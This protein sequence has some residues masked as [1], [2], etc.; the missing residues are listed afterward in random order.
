MHDL[1]ADAALLRE[2]HQPGKPVIFAN[3]WDAASAKVVAQAGAKAIATSSIAVANAAGLPDTDVMPPEVAFGAVA[4]VS[5]AVTLPVTADLEAGYRLDASEF[6]SRLLQAGAVGCNIEDTDH[7]GAHPEGGGLVPLAVQAEKLAALRAAATAAGVPIVLNAR[8]DMFLP[9]RSQTPPTVEAAIERGLAYL[10]A[11]ADCIYPI[12]LA[13]GE[14]I[15]KLTKAFDGRLNILARPGA[16]SVK[17]LG[18]IG[19]TRISVGGGMARVATDALRAAA[20][21]LLASGG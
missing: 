19:I 3:V 13:D 8:I 16:P 1:H 5:A 15:R 21:E 4:R 10:A 7:H 2:L 12:F 11:G 20:T 18:E 9:N 6:I 14:I 17:E